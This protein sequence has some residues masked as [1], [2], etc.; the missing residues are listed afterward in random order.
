MKYSLLLLFIFTSCAVYPPVTERE[1]TDITDFLNK[2]D[3]IK[4]WIQEDCGSC[5]TSTLPTAKPGAI[6][7]FDLKYTDWMS[8]MNAK[9]LEKTFIQRLGS[10]VKE[11]NRQIVSDT[12]GIELYKRK[13]SKPL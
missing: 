9:Q 3:K 4:E 6:R 12:L 8:R 1:M 10:T 2:Q 5:H 13:R 7:V 11:E